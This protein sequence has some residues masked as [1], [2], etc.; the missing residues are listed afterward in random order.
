MISL[1]AFLVSREV[2]PKHRNS[3]REN[4]R[5]RFRTPEVG[6]NRL[7]AP[8]LRGYPTAS[9]NQP[10]SCSMAFAPNGTHCCE[11]RRHAEPIPPGLPLNGS[12]GVAPNQKYGCTQ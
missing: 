8:L 1:R 2:H 6:L 5:A 3:H 9:Q 11:P 4:L 12:S 7:M 10:K